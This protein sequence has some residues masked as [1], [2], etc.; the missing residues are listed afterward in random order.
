MIGVQITGDTAL[1]TK[2]EETTGK[3]KAAAKTSLDMWATELAGYIKMSKLS[4]DPLHR[5]SG[6][7]SS[8]VYPDKRETADTISGGARAG[9]DVPYPKAHEYGM[10]RNVVVSAFHRMQTMA[11]GKPMANPREVLVNQHSSY[12]NLPERSYMRSALREQAPE[13]IA[14]LRAAVKEAIGL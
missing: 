4:G 12:V 5:R 2:L 7:L 9:L 1:V 6:K 11:W 3:I 8:S 13:G 14:E 10:Q